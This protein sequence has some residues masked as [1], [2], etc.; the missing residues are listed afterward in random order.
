[1][2]TPTHSKDLVYNDSYY[3]FKAK[4]FLLCKSKKLYGNEKY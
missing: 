2:L 1:M 3:V 4:L